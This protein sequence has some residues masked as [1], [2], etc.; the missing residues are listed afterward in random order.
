M[1]TRSR[2]PDAVAS[3]TAAAAVAAVAASNT[4]AASVDA[5]NT[6]AAAVDAVDDASNTAVVAVA[7]PLS[8][9]GP[10]QQSPAAESNNPLLW[11]APV[12]A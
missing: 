6:A 8:H 4:A 10:N 5:S 1:L 9:C 7:P 11:T 2:A 12:N 3:N